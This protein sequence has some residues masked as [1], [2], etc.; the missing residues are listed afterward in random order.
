MLIV[1]YLKYEHLSEVADGGSRVELPEPRAGCVSFKCKTLPSRL[2]WHR[3]IKP[4]KRKPGGKKATFVL[5]SE[6]YSIP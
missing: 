5:S 3:L 2:S 6:G 4:V 1:T